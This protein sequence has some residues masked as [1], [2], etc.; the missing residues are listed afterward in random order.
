M[1]IGG[2]L[3]QCISV[4]VLLCLQNVLILFSDGYKHDFIL[5]MLPQVMTILYYL[6][7]RLFV[8][9]LRPASTSIN[10]SALLTTLLCLPALVDSYSMDINNQ[11]FNFLVLVFVFL[12]FTTRQYRFHIILKLFFYLF[13]T[14]II[15][16]G[17]I[18]L[19]AT[20]KLFGIVAWICYSLYLLHT[21]TN[22][23]KSQSITLFAALTLF[24]ILIHN[25]DH[26]FDVHQVLTGMFVFNRRILHNLNLFVAIPSTIR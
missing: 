15:A 23:V 1:P 13:F 22:I 5:D 6:Q 4:A 2:V 24:S 9:T 16:Y 12:I 25:H 11:T 19:H 7:I 8:K 21:H 3:G 20:V 17:H 18:F 26:T 10:Q 14:V